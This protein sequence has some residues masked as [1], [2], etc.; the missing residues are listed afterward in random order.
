MSD[1]A[2]EFL[3]CKGIW[4]DGKNL[5]SELDIC[6]TLYSNDTL[7]QCTYSHQAKFSHL[8]NMVNEAYLIGRLSKF[9][10]TTYYIALPRVNVFFAYSYFFYKLKGG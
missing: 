4:D 5:D 2:S 1:A 10:E 3:S 9:I 6:L 8:Q 7:D